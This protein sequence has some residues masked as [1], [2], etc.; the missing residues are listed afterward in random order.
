[1][2]TKRAQGA[3]DIDEE[4]LTTSR[5]GACACSLWLVAQPAPSQLTIARRSLVTIGDPQ[6]KTGE[7]RHTNFPSSICNTC[8]ILLSKHAIQ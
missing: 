1:M 5:Q 3:A 8:T 2:I 6:S 4:R 7:R